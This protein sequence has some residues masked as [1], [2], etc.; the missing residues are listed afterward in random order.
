MHTLFDRGEVLDILPIVGACSRINH[1]E[2]KKLESLGVRHW[3]HPIAELTLPLG[4]RSD[5][6]YCS[7]I[8]MQL[9]P[10]CCALPLR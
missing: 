6:S 8:C 4:N 3:T 1:G 9:K 10:S 5:L 2:N 7:V